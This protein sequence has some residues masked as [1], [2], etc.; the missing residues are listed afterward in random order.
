MTIKQPD[1]TDEKYI[2]TLNKGDFFGEKAL[3]GY[4]KYNKKIF[5]NLFIDIYN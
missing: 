4:V 1:T 2:R 3:Q 5:G